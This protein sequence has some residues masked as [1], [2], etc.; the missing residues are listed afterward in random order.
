MI[1]QTEYS[2]KKEILYDSAIQF[3][4]AGLR[5]FEQPEPEKFK[6][7]LPFAIIVN[8]SFSAEL[9]LKYILELDGKVE[10]GHKLKLLFKKL[11][12]KD[13]ERIITSMI[14]HMQVKEQNQDFIKLGFNK[15]LERHSD[16]FYN[17]RYLHQTIDQ[18]SD[19]KADY[20]FLTKMPSF[21][22]SL[23]NE[24]RK[25]LGLKIKV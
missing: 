8:L 18:V 12:K 5:C 24:K 2:G 16:L 25:E 3:Q 1:H 9:F 4:K 21:L 7:P 6:D 13:Q 17:Y 15:M 23:S 20:G 22:K 19:L 10:K 14:Y 11:D